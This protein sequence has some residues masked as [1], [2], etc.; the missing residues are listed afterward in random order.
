MAE[1]QPQWLTFDADEEGKLTSSG[2][3]K[4]RY[5]RL[6]LWRFDNDYWTR[7][8]GNPHVDDEGKL[9]MGSG[10]GDRR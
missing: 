8:G 10:Q 1:A 5:G 2:G 7:P 4:R 3:W 9:R 6:E